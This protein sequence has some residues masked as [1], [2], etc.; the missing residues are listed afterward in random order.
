M[1]SHLPRSN[2]EQHSL[3][4]K[5]NGF[6]EGNLYGNTFI[7][8]VEFTS[9]VPVRLIFMEN[10]GDFYSSGYNLKIK[11]KLMRYIIT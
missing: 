10:C 11:N 2:R 3:R 1:K 6:F 8:V 4:Q 5:C 7:H 9:F